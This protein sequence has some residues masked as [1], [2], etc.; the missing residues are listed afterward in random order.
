MLNP[1]RIAFF[2]T[3]VL[4]VAAGAHANVTLPDV[5]GD[6]MVLQSGHGVPIWGTAN[7]GEAIT[8]RFAN[9]TKKTVAGADGKWRA[10]LDAL[11][12]NA[13]PRELTV[14][15]HNTVTL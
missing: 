11:R 5:L 13:T 3:A 2:L 9:Q 15:G 7:P 8:V 10:T 1:R 6:S 14:S 4:A 12:V